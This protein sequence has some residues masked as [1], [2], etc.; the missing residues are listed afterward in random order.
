MGETTRRNFLKSAGA[1]AGGICVAKLSGGIGILSA[2]T[3]KTDGRIE[4]TRL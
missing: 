2:S 3:K 1:V 4:D